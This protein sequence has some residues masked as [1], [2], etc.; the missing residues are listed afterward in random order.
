MSRVV[1]AFLVWVMVFAMPVQG[2]AASMM[3]FCGPGHVHMG[4]GAELD[5]AAPPAW[6]GEP[7]HEHAAAGHAMHAHT[8]A[9]DDDEASRP[10]AEAGMDGAEG[11]LAPHGKFSCSACAACCTALALPASFS[12]PEAAGPALPRQAAASA[13]VV[14][15][16]P[17]GPDRPPRAVLA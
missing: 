17:D 1:R 12:L 3:R 9:H 7:G 16:H 2:M 15:H 14:S 6:V 13:P 10:S 11:L 8:A 5:A 4:Q